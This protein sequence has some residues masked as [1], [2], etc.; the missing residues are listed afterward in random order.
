MLIIIW[1][2]LPL[3]LI[4]SLVLLYLLSVTLVFVSFLSFL[5]SFPH[6]S[7]FFLFSR[8]LLPYSFSIPSSPSVHRTPPLRYDQ[9]SG[10][11]WFFAGGHLVKLAADGSTAL[12]SAQ[13]AAAG[14][15][16]VGLALD[17]CGCLLV[18]VD[19]WLHC[20]CQESGE[21]LW[22][23]ELREEHLDEGS[24]C[25]STKLAVDSKGR[26]YV[27]YATKVVILN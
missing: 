9:T 4:Y 3:S 10:C 2:A 7:I 19:R 21:S 25:T 22:S 14:V 27:F 1:L 11:L 12:R 17:D 23:L 16:Q 24:P 20:L 18:I 6:L 15:F 8:S 5:C 13:F 26:V